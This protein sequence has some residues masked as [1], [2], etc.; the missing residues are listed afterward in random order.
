MA[1][2]AAVGTVVALIAVHDVV[3]AAVD[4]AYD[5]AAVIRFEL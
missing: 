1:A 3:N 2:V 5:V 4:V